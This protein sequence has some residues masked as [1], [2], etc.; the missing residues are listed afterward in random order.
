[1]TTFSITA[2]HCFEG[3][4]FHTASALAPS[5]KGDYETLSEPKPLPK[6]FMPNFVTVDYAQ[7]WGEEYKD[8]FTKADLQSAGETKYR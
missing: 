1:M 3:F 2:D 4:L 5:A 7:T 8:W 6:D